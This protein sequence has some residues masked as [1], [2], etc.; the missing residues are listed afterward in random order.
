[1]IRTILLLALII[2]AST[3]LTAC[4]NPLKNDSAP[5]QQVQEPP[6]PTNLNAG[7]G[8]QMNDPN[9]G[10]FD[11]TIRDSGEGIE[12]LNITMDAGEFFFAPNTITARPGQ[13]VTVTLTNNEGMMPHDFVID[14]LDVASQEIM[15]GD[16][17]VVSFTIPESSAG[18]EYEFYCSIG[19]H[20]ANGMVGTLTVLAD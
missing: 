19:D 4:T 11:D 20:R 1:M 7:A 13:M 5:E 17:T 18:Q 12:P 10:M 3:I 8:D 2:G 16:E 9:N 15:K 6:M 14:E